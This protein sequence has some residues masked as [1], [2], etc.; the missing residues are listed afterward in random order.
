MNLVMNVIEE[1][2]QSF[3]CLEMNKFKQIVGLQT[4]YVNKEAYITNVVDTLTQ[5][6]G[7]V[8]HRI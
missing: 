8:R 7:D 2:F 4:F 3:G 1:G 6:T 5:I